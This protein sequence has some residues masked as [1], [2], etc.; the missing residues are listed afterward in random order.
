MAKIRISGS[1]DYIYVPNPLMNE[2]ESDFFNR[3]VLGYGESEADFKLKYDRALKLK[4]PELLSPNF[5]RSLDIPDRS[6]TEAGRYYDLP[7]HELE[8]QLKDFKKRGEHI[9]SRYGKM[10]FVGV[11]AGVGAG[12]GAILSQWNN[13]K[14]RRL[15]ELQLLN[16][17]IPEDKVKGIIR[18]NNIRRNLIGAGVGAVIGGGLGY[19]VNRRVY[20]GYDISD[21][22]DI[23]DRIK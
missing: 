4:N 17:G 3:E 20:K 11:G 19:G 14:N 6:S 21:Y 15:R 9:N 10:K 13:S 2:A 16:Q 1:D 7:A 5:R 18:K 23:A 8:K 22:K 12:A